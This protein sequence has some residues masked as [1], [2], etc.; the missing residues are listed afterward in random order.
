[1][2]YELHEHQD[3]VEVRLEGLIGSVE[4]FERVLRAGLGN[5]RV[6]INLASVQEIVADAYGLAEQ[7][8][9]AETLGYR[10]AIYAPRPALFGLSRQVLLL[11][12]VREGVSAS[13]FSDLEAAK[14]WLRAG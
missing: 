13:V 4:H 3:Y 5:R 1:M 14:A 12:N 10:V 9:Q 8:H 6:I 2:P 7:A 11:G